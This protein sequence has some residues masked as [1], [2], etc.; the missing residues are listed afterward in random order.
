MTIRKI[1]KEDERLY[2][3]MAKDFYSSPAVLENI[4]QDNISSSFCA[5]LE[6]TPYGDAF[7][8]EEEGEAVGYGVLAYTWSQE[9]GGRVVWIEE[10]YIKEEFRS[11][12]IGSGFIRYVLSEI[13]AKRYRLETEPEN[14]KAAALYRRLGFEFFEYVNYRLDR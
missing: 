1:T 2:T 6:G 10:I 8:I 11:R 12:G 14:E 9:A 7:I 13:P 4:P 3:E 5:F